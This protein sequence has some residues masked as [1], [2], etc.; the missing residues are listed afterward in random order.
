MHEDG[1]SAHVILMR[2][3]PEMMVFL[4]AM[5]TLLNRK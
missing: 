2:R 4:H 1:L 5:L 3:V